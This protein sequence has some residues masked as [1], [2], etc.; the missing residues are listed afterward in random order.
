MP[1]LKAIRKRITSV[2][3]TQKITRAMKMVA[4]ARL[5]RAQQRITELRPYAIK[6]Q[7]VLAAI[8]ASARA[9]SA[10]DAGQGVPADADVVLE[11]PL[12]PLLVERPERRVM[13]LILTS[14]R[15]L[16]GAFNTNINKRAERE[17]KSRV[18]QGQEV[19]MK[20]I[21]R[22]GRDYMS[23]RNAPN[24]GYLP[25]VWEKLALETAQRVGKEILDPFLKGEVDSIYVIYNEFKSAVT[26]QVVVER[27]LPVR[28]LAEG[29]QAEA[30]SATEFIFEPSREALL[31]V[32]APMYV[33]ISLLRALYESMASEF[34]AKLT[35][36]DA[37][38]KNA[39]EMVE[40]LTLEYNRA[41]QAA[42]TKELMEIIG[43]S[44]AL[45]D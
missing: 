39:K 41:R 3:S 6:T 30:T 16:C 36:M 15:G 33:D 22:K 12:H 14:D 37:A 4:G 32:L 40:R 9:A 18:D 20:V 11:R 34:G 17:W 45:K 27:L 43:G 25:G 7:E 10:Q 13:L 38:T 21:G 31:D 26:Q 35:A 23:R 29:D 19:T 44:E 5:N 28:P 42:I 24:L 8:T 2:R 1:S